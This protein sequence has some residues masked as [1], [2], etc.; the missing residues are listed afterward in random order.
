MALDADCGSSTVLEVF[1]VASTVGHLVTGG[2]W[3]MCNA[4]FGKG[5]RA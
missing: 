5:L 1:C 4:R 3:V 2:C